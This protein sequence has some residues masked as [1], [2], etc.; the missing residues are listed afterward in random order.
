MSG[1][2]K[3]DKVKVRELVEY[4]GFKTLAAAGLFLQR[5]G[6]GINEVEGIVTNV[7]TGVSILLET[8][9]YVIGA[10]TQPPIDA[11]IEYHRHALER[12]EEKKKKNL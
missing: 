10:L 7:N 9:K 5:I 8:G 4:G 11:A 2:E 1:E 12:L 6:K 3:K